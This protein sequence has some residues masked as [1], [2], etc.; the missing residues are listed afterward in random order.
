MA[1]KSRWQQFSDNFNGVYGTFQKIGKDIESGRVMRNEYEDEDGNALSGDA[2]DRRRMEELSK[3]YTKYGD[4]KGGLGLR[5]QQAKIEADKRNNDLQSRILDHLVKQQGALKTSQMESNIE[6]T[7]AT[8]AD[9]RSTTNRRNTLLPIEVR[10]GEATVDNTVA[11]TDNI[12]STM[13]RRDALL[14]HEVENQSLVNEGLGSTN[15]SSAAKADVDEALVNANINQ[16]IAES[17]SAVSQSLVDA[18]SAE[19]S[20]K[21]LESTVASTNTKN[22]ADT[23]GNKLKTLQSTIA[24][25]ELDAEEQL[26][27]ELNNTEFDSP[28]DAQAAYLEMV[29]NDSRIAPERKAAIIKAVNNVGLATMQTEAAN[30][31][32]GGKNALQKGGLDG[33]VTYYDGIDDG[34]TMRIERGDDGS[35]SVIATRGDVETVLFSDNSEDAE[36]VVT[37]QMFNQVS[38]P[39][40]GFEVVA[41]AA[42]VQKTRAETERTGSQTVLLDRQAF[43]ELL[44]QDTELARQNLIEAQTAEIDQKMEL[45]GR[46]LSGRAK[47]AEEGLADLLSKDQYILMAEDDPETAA[48]LVGD[49][50]RRYQM[51]G[52]PPQGVEAQLWFGMTEQEQAEFLEDM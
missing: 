40:T 37:Q 31:A 5:A 33:L 12:R 14:P 35:I 50:M 20:D 47:I 41:Q 23:A 15:R 42:D 29:R 24:Y 25:E 10:Q 16:G 48:N 13:D 30:L 1:R 39:G 43:S 11:S 32:Q 9:T 2:L 52:A 45:A 18:D 17:S 7:D 44:S 38:R 34:D 3:V 22:E 19:I 21:T 51:K 49:Y 4:A 8:T 26:L 46:G 6:K 36:A 28:D 27:V